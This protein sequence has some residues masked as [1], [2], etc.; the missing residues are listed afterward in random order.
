MTR[1][2]AGSI[3]AERKAAGEELCAKAFDLKPL[4]PNDFI[5]NYYTLTFLQ[6]ILQSTHS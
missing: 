3:D 6:Y 5:I 1:I 2:R 4:I